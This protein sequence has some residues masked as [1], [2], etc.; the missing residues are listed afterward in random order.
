MFLQLLPVYETSFISYCAGENTVTYKTKLEKC[1]IAPRKY[2]V[3][4]NSDCDS[5]IYWLSVHHLDEY[6][7]ISP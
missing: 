3:H 5:Q 7:I 6:P 2:F 1:Q 4:R